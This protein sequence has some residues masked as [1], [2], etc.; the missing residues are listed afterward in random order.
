MKKSI[1]ALKGIGNKISKTTIKIIAGSEELA[2][3][4][5]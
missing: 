1:V 3:E 2:A 4:L 5:D